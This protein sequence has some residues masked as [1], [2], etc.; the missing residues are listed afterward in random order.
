MKKG[1]RH[2]G[3]IPLSREHHYGLMV[4]LRIHQGIEQHKADVDWP[5]QGDCL[6]FFVVRI[7]D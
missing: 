7:S 4:C 2:D 1:G 5:N 3:V 6:D